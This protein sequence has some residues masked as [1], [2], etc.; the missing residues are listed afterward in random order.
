M[1]TADV[2]SGA[3]AR[4]GWRQWA[5][6]AV[7]CLP[8]ML[9]TVDITVMFLALP[10]VSADLG[11]SGVEQ[12]WISD[13][14]GFMIA[15]FLVTMGTLG[16]RIGRRRVLLAGAAVFV[17][18]SLL[19]AWST[20]TAMLI[21]A[22]ALLGV[23]GATVAPSVLALI[24]DMFPD[25]R[26][27]GTAMGVWGSS[28]MAGVI[29]GPVVGGLLLG[30]FPWG[31][32]F[33]MAVPVMG[34]LLLTAPFL[35]PES[36]DPG[37]GRLDW[38][39]VL[40]SLGAVLP[41][42]YGLKELAR[43]GWALPPVAA[44]LLGAVC[45]PVFVRR[46]RAL[47]DPLLDLRLFG[48]RALSGTMSLSLMF[49]FVMGGTGLVATLFLQLVQG[50]TPFDVALWMVVPALTMI[51]VGNVAGAAAR[52]V[53]PAYLIAGGAVLAA[54]GMVVLT[55][56]DAV[57]G[58]P[59]LIAGLVMVYAGGS[60]ITVLS[61]LLVMTSAPPERA[62]SA[63]SLQST[64]SEFGTALGVAVLGLAATAVYRAHVVVPAGLPAG[65]A[66]TARESLSG[67]VL[68]AQQ[69]PGR[70]GAELLASAR[71]AFTGGLHVTALI[72]AVVFLGLAAVALAGLRHVPPTGAAQAA[73]PQE[74][75]AHPAG[76]PA[77]T[78]P[79]KTGRVETGPAGTGGPGPARASEGSGG[80]SVR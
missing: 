8:T 72:A 51:V 61:P 73:G 63:G 67:A 27:M 55:R 18:A 76:G 16:D 77:G 1:T 54:A 33:L 66:A 38:V 45:A 3:P 62:G 2:S 19:A 30:A 71:D 36:R 52:A 28:I 80:V 6:L 46:Q 29:L 34:L 65:T 53:R 13:V 15:G 5:G 50:L 4:A 11:A 39:S 32:I 58:L 23:A 20:S 49:A 56:V 40:L 42:V 44:I 75:D 59:V 57:G 22:R 68:T 26:Q 41:L 7:M 78:G 64:G 9:T 60:P 31:S 48:V 37:A 14:Y 69:V 47:A 79:E 70:A 21:G 10:H 74:A 24:R 43:N 25:P 17:A 12:L 35:V